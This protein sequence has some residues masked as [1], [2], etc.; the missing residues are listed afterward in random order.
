MWK[1]NQNK[2]KL[3]ICV[4]GVGRSGTTGLYTLLQEILIDNFG[5]DV[6]FVYEPFMWDKDAFNGRYSEVG[7]NFKYM[8]SIS[9]EGIYHHL[10]LPLFI[11]A[12]GKFEENEY[13]NRIFQKNI[14]H[15][16]LLVKFVRANGRYLLLNKICP[17]CKFVFIIRNPIDVINSAIV[18]FSFFGSEFHRDDF[19]RF[20]NEINAAYDMEYKLG[21]ILNQVEKEVLYWYYM[22]KY[23]LES[24]KK[25]NRKPLIICY[26]DYVSN[27]RLWVDRICDLLEI[28]KKEKYYKFSEAQGG[29]STKTANLNKFE[30]QLLTEYIDKYKELLKN[31]GIGNNINLN[32]IMAKYKNLPNKKTQKLIL[33]MTPNY[34]NDRMIKMDQMLEQKDKEI[35]ILKHRLKQIDEKIDKFG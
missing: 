34:M 10:K 32:E 22:N 17:E 23:A 24:F 2:Q 31:Q 1:L 25:V 18:R 7:K 20:L 14:L 15:S 12:P 33:G 35:Q 4:L 21:K 16:T 19:K 8:D 6:D 29:S 13:L 28:Q 9:I 30:F 5:D 27:R 26:E 3:K 11:T